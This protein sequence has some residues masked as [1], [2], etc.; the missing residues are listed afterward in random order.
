MSAQNSHSECRRTRW[1]APKITQKRTEFSVDTPRSDVRLSEFTQLKLGAHRLRVLRVGNIRR[2]E[3]VRVHHVV[4]KYD[5]EIEDFHAQTRRTTTGPRE[6]LK[7]GHRHIEIILY[8]HAI[9]D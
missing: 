6:R 3:F 5:I 4:V 7:H 1:R 8:A 9:L 2:L